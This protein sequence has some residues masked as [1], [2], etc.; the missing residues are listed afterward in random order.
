MHPPCTPYNV[1][2]HDTVAKGSRPGALV[3]ER[4]G[5]PQSRGTHVSPDDGAEDDVGCHSPLLLHEY[6][7]GAE[8]GACATY[9]AA[10][11]TLH[12]LPNTVALLL[13]LLLQL[14]AASELLTSSLPQLRGSHTRPL[15]DEIHARLAPH[16]Y[17][18]SDE[19]ATCT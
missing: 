12:V 7:M 14:V 16:T 8:D 15:P 11:C 6:D 10:H 19:A 2:V 18:E 17:D 4:V 3:D 9:P 5:T 1:L 13:L